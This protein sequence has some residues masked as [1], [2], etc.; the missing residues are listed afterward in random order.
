MSNIKLNL[1]AAPIWSKD[2]WHVLDHKLKKTSGNK[3][4][5]DAENIKLKNSSCSIVFTSH[6]FEHIPN[7]RLPLICL[8]YT[9]D[10]ADE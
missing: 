2:D 10:A 9:S 8:L 7:I 5:G 6:V 4:A 1:G 3:I